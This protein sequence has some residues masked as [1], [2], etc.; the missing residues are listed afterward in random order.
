MRTRHRLRLSPGI[1]HNGM[2]EGDSETLYTEPPRT[3][4]LGL[5]YLHVSQNDTRA[6]TKLVRAAWPGT[7]ILNPHPPGSDAPAS[8]EDDADAVRSGLTDAIPGDA[9]SDHRRTMRSAEKHVARTREQGGRVP[10]AWLAVPAGPLS[11]GIAGPTLV[12]ADVARDLGLTPAAV[13]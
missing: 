1:T 13:T 8:P 2:D 10:A 3:P 4:P 12:L 7:L 6:I 9:R 5:A 11:F